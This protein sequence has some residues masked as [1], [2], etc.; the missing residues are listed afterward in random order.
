MVLVRFRTIAASPQFGSVQPGQIVSVP[1]EQADDLVRHG[2]AERVHPVQL[3]PVP[4]RETAELTGQ[5]QAML[6]PGT[7]K[8]RRRAT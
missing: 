3:D 6:P 5:E 8:S 2:Y 4:V 7:P 1:D